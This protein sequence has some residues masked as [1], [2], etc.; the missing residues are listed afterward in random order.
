L[1]EI[2]VHLYRAEDPGTGRVEF[3]YDHVLRG[4][5]AA[6]RSVLPDPDEV[7][8][9][10][11]MYPDELRADLDA[12]PTAYAPWLG[13]VLSR[14][15]SAGTTSP[16]A[17][18]PVVVPPAAGPPTGTRKPGNGGRWHVRS[19]TGSEED[20]PAERSGGR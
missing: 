15:T 3:E 18:P 7:A 19:A 5:F 11:W 2:G 8:D 9:L 16:T 14:L 6:D 1:T 4:E 10:R 17:G 12:D 20:N 13:G